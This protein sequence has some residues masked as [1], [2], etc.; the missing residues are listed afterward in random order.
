[1]ALLRMMLVPFQC[2]C[3]VERLLRI[4]R[5]LPFPMMWREFSR[6]ELVI[7]STFNLE[8]SLGS[9]ELSALYGMMAPD[10]IALA[11]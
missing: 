2:H 7:N 11:K 1:M 5:S 3:L 9:H 10:G 6:S 4:V 8:E